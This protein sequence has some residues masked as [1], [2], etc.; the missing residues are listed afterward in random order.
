MSG[1]LSARLDPEVHGTTAVTT[2]ARVVSLLS[3]M[4][5]TLV[6]LY[7]AFTGSSNG[8]YL[9]GVVVG[10][11]PLAGQTYSTAHRQLASDLAD[12][13]L[14]LDIA[15]RPRQVSPAEVGV[16]YDLNQTLATAYTLGRSD[17]AVVAGLP[18]PKLPALRYA[19]TVNQDHLKAFAKGIS[20]ELG[21]A[22]ID[23]TIVIR[24]GIP[25]V[26]VDKSGWGVNERALRQVLVASLAA[27]TH[28]SVSVRPHV[29]P[30][31]VQS[32]QVVPAL[33][34]TKQILVT[35]I[36]LNYDD[37]KF[38]PNSATV[39]SWI[40]YEVNPNGLGLV[41]KIDSSRLK[42]YI[43]QIANQIN[44]SPVNKKVTVE[45]GV[46]AVKQEGVDGLSVDQDVLTGAVSTSLLAQTPLDLVIATRPVPFKTETTNHVSLDYGRYIEINLNLQHLWVYQDH[47]VIY[48]SAITTGATGA[49]LGTVTGLFSINYKT[50]NTRLRGYQYGYNYDVPVKYW[51]PFYQGYGLHD[52]VW[53]NGKFG[54]P[55]YYYGGSH[56]CVNL[57]DA[58]AEFIYNW[59]AVGTPVWVHN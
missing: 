52:A 6:A 44:V 46:T 29:V 21:I 1:F 8:R 3:G 13:R 56:G 47:Q 24:E 34:E 35:P 45:N 50:T 32:S 31:R 14:R 18:S 54:G 9:P 57:P 42:D 19:Y 41:P 28:E 23:A 11:R 2:G 51:M 43:N 53:R 22:P 58:T 30:A 39:G 5:L 12:Y 15:G 27:G 10:D 36:V 26:S 49:G 38:K 48:D 33:D 7:L 25:S 17:E 16:N 59:A 20:D 55:D 40:I 37:K 4:G